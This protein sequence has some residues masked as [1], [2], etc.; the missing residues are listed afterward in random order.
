M[1]ALE[2]LINRTSYNKLTEPA[3]SGAA[4]DNIFKA[5]VA[6]PD[7][8]GLTP[9]RFIVFKDQALQDLGEIFAEAAEADQSDCEKI[10][11]AKKM[12]LRAPLIIAVIACLDPSNKIPVSE[13]HLTAGCAAQAM[14]MAAVAQGFQGIWR[15][16]AYSYHQ[17]VTTQLKL[18]ENEKIVGFLYLGTALDAVPQKTRPA[19]EP[20]I[21]YW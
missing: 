20:L 7:H 15:S 19:T 11:K 1:Q 8:G 6:A 5:A 21:Q 17:H 4:L 14:Q 12:P 9:Y 13:Q 16:G 2:L 10:E 18:S 3:P